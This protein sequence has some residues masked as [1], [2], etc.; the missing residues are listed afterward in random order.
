[1]LILLV[2]SLSSEAA[3]AN[4]IISPL[5]KSSEAFDAVVDGVI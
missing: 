4:A 1:M 2:F 3:A 5:T